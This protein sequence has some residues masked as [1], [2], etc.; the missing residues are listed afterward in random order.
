[1]IEF[2]IMTNVK[3]VAVSVVYGERWELLS[4][5]A[6]AVL[7][8][9]KIKTFVIVDN[10]SANFEEMKAELESYGDRVVILQQFKNIGY[11]GAIAKG[12]AYARDIECD[13]IFVLDDDSVPEEGAVDY[14]LEALK[15]FPDDKVIL[16]GNRVNVPGNKDVFYRKPLQNVAPRGTLFEVFS[17]SKLRNIF[18]LLSGRYSEAKGTF[19][20]IVPTEAFV[21]GGSF[22]P[23]SAV[24]LAPLPDASLF[25]YGEDLEYSWA[26]KRLGY[27]SY[28]CARPKIYDIDL[29]FPEVGQHIFGLFK[30]ETP[31][32][33][34]YLRIRNAI[35]VSRRNTA[36]SSTVLFLNI[37]V[38]TVGLILIG[39]LSHGFKAI[40][41][42][43]VR[44]MLIATVRGYRSNMELPEGVRIP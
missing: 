15:L 5:V 2:V 11:S 29:T 9:S 7:K 26:I 16:A 8:D 40:Y 30:E 27:S 37:F 14:F 34:V 23:V 35:I 25:M 33:K 36:Q 24:R 1:M 20:P 22:M 6:D 38:W 21:T 31:E 19:I 43:R 42:K 10:G 3:V 18:S 28:V 12:L 32:Y 4:K 44:L 39:F 41:F 13:Y 17:F